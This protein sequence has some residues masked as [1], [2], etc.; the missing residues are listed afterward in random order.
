[1]DFHGINSAIWNCKRKRDISGDS[2][3]ISNCLIVYH[4]YCLPV[5][6][7][8]V[9]GHVAQSVARLTH[10]PEVPG[11]IPGPATYFRFSFC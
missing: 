6:T 11:S 2:A 5:L 4:V 10:E 1:M 7:I 9:Q 3:K 8:L